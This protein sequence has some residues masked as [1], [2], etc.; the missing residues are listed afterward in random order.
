M[1]HPIMVGAVHFDSLEAALEA[2]HYASE[3]TWKGREIR[4]CYLQ[5]ITAFATWQVA[6]LTASQDESLDIGRESHALAL[7]ALE[8][9]TADEDPLVVSQTHILLRGIENT[10]PVLSALKH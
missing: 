9:A 4:K 7:K 5:Y 3:L 10:F 8:Q 2:L 6:R 1:V